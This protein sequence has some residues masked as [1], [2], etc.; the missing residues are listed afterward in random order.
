M[1]QVMMV[2]SRAVRIKCADGQP[3]RALAPISQISEQAV[4]TYHNQPG[5]VSCLNEVSQS[6]ALEK[7]PSGALIL[8]QWLHFIAMSSGSNRSTIR[9]TAVSFSFASPRASVA[10]QRF[11]LCFV[12]TSKAQ[13][14]RGRAAYPPSTGQCSSLHH[15]ALSL[16]W[17]EQDA[18]TAWY[19]TLGR[20]Y[21]VEKFDWVGW[22]GVFTFDP[23]GNTV[24]L[25][26]KDP[27][28]VA[29]SSA[30]AEAASR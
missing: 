1:E 3:T 17:D 25:V 10:I 12:T 19:E 29:P 16:P 6:A 27:S 30:A 15:I 18:V 13:A 8:T 22:R 5:E 21:S 4:S 24:E 23:D 14:R 20:K 11:W 28:W 26:A 2:V 9:T 7:S